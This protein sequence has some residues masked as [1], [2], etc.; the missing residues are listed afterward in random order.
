[1]RA[2]SFYNFASYIDEVSD[3]RAYGGKSLHEHPT[4]N[5]SFL[6]LP[7]DSS[8]EMYPWD[9]SNDRIRSVIF[10]PGWEQRWGV[11][12]DDLQSKVTGARLT[13]DEFNRLLHG[14]GDDR[15]L[16][17]INTE[18]VLIEALQDPDMIVASDAGTLRDRYEHPRTAGPTPAFSGIL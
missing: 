18:E 2:E 7:I 16:M 4:V 13:R 15:V 17:H 14:T 9:A 11:T 5:L 1:M 8:T 3:L 6:C 12:P 10:E